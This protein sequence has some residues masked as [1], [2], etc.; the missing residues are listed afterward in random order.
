MTT[1]KNLEMHIYIC[2]WAGHITKIGDNEC[3]MCSLI[4]IEYLRFHDFAKSIVI[5]QIIGRCAI[6]TV[7]NSIQLKLILHMQV[8]VFERT[9]I[10]SCIYLNTHSLAGHTLNLK[11]HFP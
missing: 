5:E 2:S 7:I 1:Q 3:A 10:S 8:D 11:M 4:L 9:Q 6:E